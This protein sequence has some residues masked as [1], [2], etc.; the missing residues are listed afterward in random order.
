M[1]F[2]ATAFE[3]VAEYE[4]YSLDD[5]TSACATGSTPSPPDAT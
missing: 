1:T 3:E 4:R 5:L 2:P